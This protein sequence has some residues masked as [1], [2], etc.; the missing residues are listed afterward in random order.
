MVGGIQD[1][2][3]QHGAIPQFL[4]GA[5]SKGGGSLRLRR[6]KAYPCPQEK[7]TIRQKFRLPKRNDM[8]KIVDMKF[9]INACDI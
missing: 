5:G 4:G 6:Q 2:G 1:S 8:F 3:V 7:S 9:A